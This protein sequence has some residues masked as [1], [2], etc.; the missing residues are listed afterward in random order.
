MDRYSLKLLG[1]FQL[2]RTARGVRFESD[3]V[4]GL[5]AFLATEPGAHRRETL[6]S[7][8]WP[9][10]PER[11]ARHN[12]SQ[13]LYNLRRV[14]PSLSKTVLEITTRTVRFAP[15][16]RFQVDA[17]LFERSL[18]AVDRHPHPLSLLCDDCRRHLETAVDLYR[19]EFLSGLRVVD[20]TA[21]EDWLRQKRD[22]YQR[23]RIEAL[24]SLAD[25][26]EMLGDYPT[27]V[28]YLHQVQISDPLD[29][30]VCRQR[31]RLL[32]LSGQRNE[33]LRQY[34]LFRQML[35][36]ELG[37]EPEESTRALYR[38]LLL[39]ETPEQDPQFPPQFPSITVEGGD[40]PWGEAQLHEVAGE[41]AR[42]RGEYAHA[43][44]FHEHALGIYR[45][46]GNRRGV[47][48]S[49]SF[50]G[51]TARDM[52]D[53]ERAR[54]FI[55]QARQI[56]H[57]LG[58]RFSSA[59]MNITLARFLS[60]LG[61]FSSTVDLIKSSIPVY[62]ELGLQQRV[63]YFTI[64]LGLNQML[65]GQYAEARANGGRGIQLSHAAGDQAGICFGMT[66]LGTI[67]VAEENEGRAEQLLKQ[68]LVLANRIGRPEELGGVLG[69]LGYIMLK[70]GNDPQAR[71]YLRDGA[72][73]VSNS[74]NVFAAVFVVPAL[75]L[76]LKM[77]G[78]DER[79]RDL[80]LLCR[81]FAVFDRS[82][83]FHT[84]Y[85]PYFG[86]WD[87]ARPERQETDPPTDLLWAAADNLLIQF[88]S[89]FRINDHGGN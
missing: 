82:A 57:E 43:R 9:E 33:A 19:G 32:A 2:E 44:D 16:E 50:L 38:Q 65:L 40:E 78:E 23:R 29:E 30:E 27:A 83:Y 67:A 61:D 1:P 72:W 71:M 58:D 54:Q 41:L 85:A 15:D 3:K 31:M 80:Y 10:K 21:F 14:I 49:L 34:E 7:L 59:E 51:L 88:G 45:A 89:I 35:W 74:H 56:Y 73:L 52:G 64:G 60:F 42:A 75:A 8:L 39:V 48:G 4:R 47:A 46:R 87:L 25:N 36:D 18:D 62:R 84:L 79:A 11:E 70:R 5:L 53:F 66:L 22:L 24:C 37:V 28:K 17:L 12:L 20:S 86:R 13:A 76:F 6:A 63:A 77:R 69:S 55:Q 68:A 81:R 26:S